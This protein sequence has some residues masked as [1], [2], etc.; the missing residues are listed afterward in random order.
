MPFLLLLLPQSDRFH[1]PL[2]FDFLFAG[3]DLQRGH[4]RRLAEPMGATVA[5]FNG[6]T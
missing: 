4:S 2:D 1:L 5:G 3:A 6:A